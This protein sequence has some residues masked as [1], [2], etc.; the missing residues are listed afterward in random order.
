M[1]VELSELNWSEFGHEEYEEIKTPSGFLEQTWTDVGEWGKGK[2]WRISFCNGLSL[3]ISDYKVFSHIRV[4]S[5]KTEDSDL[6]EPVIN[7]VISGTVRTI[8]EGLTDYTVEVPGKNYLEFIEGGIESEDWL[9]G[10]RVLKVRVGIELEALR[11]MSQGSVSTLPKELQLLV[12]GETIT[13]CYRLETT[14]SQMDAVLQQILHCPYSGW[15]RQFYLES[16]A[17]ELLILWL[18]QTGTKDQLPKS[19]KLSQQDL[20]R[21]QAAKKILVQN[22]DSPP[23]LINLARQV[24]LNDYK[25]KFGF[26]EVF[27]TTV[28]G[29][30]HA[31]RMEYAQKL[32]RQK[33]MKVTDVAYAVGYTSLPSFSK[34]FRKHF[35]VSPRAYLI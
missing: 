33:R 5:D 2:D 35:G 29:Y 21:L 19:G 20:A 13:P 12:E 18:M 34:A 25:L 22:L 32:L 9:G 11:K 1:T 23:S 14:T 28:F 15:T 6:I 3:E 7:F 17:M 27:G 4:D 16:K 10:D 31:K 24:G 8:H 26:R 30:L